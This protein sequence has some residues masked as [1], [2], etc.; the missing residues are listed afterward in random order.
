MRRTL[1][2]LLALLVGPGLAACGKDKSS[3]AVKTGDTSSTSSA[4]VTTEVTAPGDSSA[5]TADTGGATGVTTVTPSTVKGTATTTRSTGSSSGGG[6][7]APGA[8][9]DPPRP[10][11]YTY[12]VTGKRS[13]PAFGE[14]PVNED[15]TLE[16]DPASGRDVHSIESSQGGSAEQVTRYGDDG[17]RLVSL[18]SSQTG[19]SKEFKPA[20]PVQ[21]LPWPV[22]D[23]QKWSWKITSTDGK[24]TVDSSFTLSGHETMTVGG[25]K[26][27]TLVIDAVVNTSG[28]ITSTTKEKIW[29]APTYRLIVE[30]QGVTDGMFGTTKFHSEQTRKLK[31][32]KPA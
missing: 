3:D 5:E 4:T 30:D 6:A 17:V 19:I 28:D 26:V 23:G 14:Q 11:K 21:I 29:V 25:E 15:A 31:S 2:L 18:K 7:V 12:A 16:I 22:K 20:Q 24:T 27:D 8:R 1:V 10:G 13:S 9:L 32:T